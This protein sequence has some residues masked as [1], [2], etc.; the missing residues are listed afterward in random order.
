MVRHRTKPVLVHWG[1]AM[2]TPTL[3]AGREAIFEFLPEK[4]PTF[5]NIY[6]VSQK[7]TRH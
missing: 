4:L 5:Q 6:T 2:Y 7:K 3:I 1:H